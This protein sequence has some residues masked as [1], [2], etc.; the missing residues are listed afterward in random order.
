[1]IAVPKKTKMDHESPGLSRQGTQLFVY[2]MTV[3]RHY[4]NKSQLL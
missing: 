4:H 3:F 1:M 2:R